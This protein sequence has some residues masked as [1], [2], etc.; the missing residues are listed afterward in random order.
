VLQGGYVLARAAGSAQV[1]ARAVDGALA[2]LGV[3]VR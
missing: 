2:M 1:H 3:M